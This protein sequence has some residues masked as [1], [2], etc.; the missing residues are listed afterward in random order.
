MSN[1]D[2]QTDWQAEND[3]SRSRCPYCD[4]N[5]PSKISLCPACGASI[6]TRREN[7]LTS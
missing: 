6:K 4:S 2:M 1:Q 7:N 3:R 5:N